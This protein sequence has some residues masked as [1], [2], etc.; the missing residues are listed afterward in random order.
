MTGNTCTN[1]VA[2]RILRPYQELNHYG[3]SVTINVGVEFEFYLSFV[4][5]ILLG[6]CKTMRLPFLIVL[7]VRTNTVS[8][9]DIAHVR[10]TFLHYGVTK[11]S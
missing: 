6:K 4:Y 11:D 8:Q 9:D 7:F 1:V 10:A 2:D 5:Q 3:Q